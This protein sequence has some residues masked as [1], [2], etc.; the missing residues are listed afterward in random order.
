MEDVL[1]QSRVGDVGGGVDQ[2]A[3]DGLGA[4]AVAVEA[5]AVVGEREQDFG[6]RVASGE[7]DV[8]GGRLAGS[9]A[10]IRIL[11][12]M[13]D[14]VAD[15]V[16]QRIGQTLDDGLVELGF[17]TRSDELQRLRKVAREIVHEAAE[18]REQRADG[19]EADA[20]GR[21]AEAVRQ[22][23][24]FL[25]HEA[26]RRVAA[27]LGDLRQARLHDDQLADAVH[28]L[29]QALGLN[30]DGGVG[31]R[32]ADCTLVGCAAACCRLRQRTCSRCCFCNLR[33]GG[34]SSPSARSME[35][36]ISST[37]KTKTYSI[38]ERGAAVV[39]R[40]VQEM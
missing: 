27:A 3:L 9:L 29:V 10:G 17:L 16:D 28:Q 7:L 12:A 24:D 30:A 20:H 8:T 40:A 21:V 39:R 11:E 19:N 14:G 34:A 22:A 23:G 18:A 33:C 25:G 36:S 15:D 13:I 5:A 32:L 1:E 37:T 26:D 2:A 4:D 35:S 31:F 6:A 38:S